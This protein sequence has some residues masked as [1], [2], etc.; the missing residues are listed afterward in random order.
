MEGNILYAVQ[1]IIFTF[2]LW[3]ILF[4]IYRKEFPKVDRMELFGCSVVTSLLI[5]ML[6]VGVL[7]MSFLESVYYSAW[8]LFWFINFS[9]AFFSAYIE[10]FIVKF[11]LKKLNI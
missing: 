7:S 3:G 2:I 4:F 1:V 10:I 5:D 6:T 11:L 9:M 8:V